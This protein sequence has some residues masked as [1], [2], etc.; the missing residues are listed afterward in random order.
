MLHRLRKPL[1]AVLT[2]LLL[3]CTAASAFAYELPEGARDTEFLTP[4]FHTELNYDEIEYVFMEA[5]PYLEEIDAL[6]ALMADAANA[7]EFESR[8]LALAEAYDRMNAMYVLIDHR[9]AADGTEPA[10]PLTGEQFADMLDAYALFHGLD[11]DT[12]GAP[13]VLTRAEMAEMLMDYRK[14]AA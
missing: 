13:T 3:I 14:A 8:F 2:L 11:L 6:R 7:G 10:A 4:V 12:E 1:S 5:A 9:A